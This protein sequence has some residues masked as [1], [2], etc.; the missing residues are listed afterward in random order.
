MGMEPSEITP[1]V[2]LYMLLFM[3][4]KLCSPF[5]LQ[6]DRGPEKFNALTNVK[7]WNRN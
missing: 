1:L 2:N 5:L 7:W 6:E 3:F 4:R